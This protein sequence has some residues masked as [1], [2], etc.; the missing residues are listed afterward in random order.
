MMRMRRQLERHGRWLF[1]IAAF[2]IFATIAAAYIVRK[3]RLRLPFEDR[4]ELQAEFDIVNGLK[5]ELSQPVNVAGVQVGTIVSAEVE[6]GSALVGMEIDPGMLPR[7]FANARA[8]LNPETP[9][10]DMQIE[11]EPGGPPAR[12]LP[13]GGTIP[14]AHTTSPIDSDELT[15]ALDADVRDH[16]GIFLA[17]AARGIRGRGEDLRELLRALGPTAGDFRRLSSALASRRDALRHFVHSYARLARA[18][19]HR[20]RQLAQLIVGAD[21]TFG[22]LA[23]EDV[24]L[25]ESLR[26][27]PGTLAATRST[28]ANTTDFA[29]ELAPTVEELRPAARRLPAALRV[30]KPLLEDAHRLTRRG[31]RPLVPELQPLARDLGPATADLTEVTPALAS[32]FAVLTYVANELAY[33]PPGDNEGFLHWFAW[34]LHNTNSAFSSEDAHGA[35]ARGFLVIDC[36]QLRS[37]PELAPLIDLLIR[38]LPGCT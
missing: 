27:L 28:L 11:L 29:G 25:R 32:A 14:L 19:G 2:A 18:T 7:V 20:D 24:A 4:Y 26:L 30:G 15:A 33:N 35:V 12:A 16:L 38:N 23:S 22:A 3:Q 36:D 10:R 17:D 37:I 31:L 21:A 34:M 9:L 6:G 13:E 1:V 5:P 8:A